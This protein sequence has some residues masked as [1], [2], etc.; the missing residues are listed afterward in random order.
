MDYM[1][2]AAQLGQAIANSG[3]MQ[4]WRNAENALIE[5]EK[6]N[7]LMEEYREVQM[8]LVKASREELGQDEIEKIRDILLAK[9]RELNEY[10]VTKNYF[11]SN[12]VFQNM[13]KSINDII[14]FYVTGEQSC[15]GSCSS[16]S[17]C[18]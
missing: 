2:A 3:E 9:Q 10:E 7:I 16:C 12:E 8:D 18:H 14:Q 11:R 1:E 15:G 4:A 13:M 17:G 6:A 5:D